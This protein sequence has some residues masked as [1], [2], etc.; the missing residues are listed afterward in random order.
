MK[1]YLIIGG[2]SGI[3]L[4][5]V[6]QLIDK[7]HQVYSTYNSNSED[8]LNPKAHYF[9]HNVLS[10]SL[11][12][13]DFAPNLDGLVYCPGSI[14][15]KPFKRLKENELIDDFKLNASGAVKSIQSALPAL[16]KN[17]KASIVLFSTVA[18]GTGFNFHTQVSMCKGA[19]EGLSISLAA[20]LAPKVRVNVISPSLTQTKLADKLLNTEQKIEANKMRHPLKQIGVPSDIANLASFLLSDD[21]S[22]ITGQNITIDGGISKLKV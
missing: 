16:I 19:I 17:G 9:K 5:I 3:G 15:L 14:N 21:A 10:D 1:N 12:S 4:S 7:G 18:V 13:E 8:K 2:S 22:W 6:N 11:S 20:E